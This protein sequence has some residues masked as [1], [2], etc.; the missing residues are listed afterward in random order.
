LVNDRRLNTQWVAG[1][2]RD[3][4]VAL[5]WRQPVDIGTLSLVAGEGLE[6]GRIRDSVLI[7]SDGSLLPVGGIRHGETVTLDL[8]R[9]EISWVK[10]FVREGRGKI[11][12]SEII[13]EEW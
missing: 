3:S 8:D 9:S 11:G 6:N 1:G 2:G 13:V 4:W 10:F 5:E 12:L 7:L